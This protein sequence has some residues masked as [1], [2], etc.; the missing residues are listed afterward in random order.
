MSRY[1][2]NLGEAAEFD[3]QDEFE[4]FEILKRSLRIDATSEAESL[5]ELQERARSWMG[6]DFGVT[7]IR[8]V[9]QNMLD[10]NLIANISS[11]SEN[12]NSNVMSEWCT[13]AFNCSS[14]LGLISSRDFGAIQKV[15]AKIR[16]IANQ[17]DN[18]TI[19]IALEC[20][21]D[22]IKFEGYDFADRFE[23]LPGAHVPALGL[24][25]FIH[26]ILDSKCELSPSFGLCQA[27]FYTQFPPIL[28]QFANF[29][30]FTLGLEMKEEFFRAGLVLFADFL[31]SNAN[32]R[33]DVYTDF[34]PATRIPEHANLYFAYGSN[35]NM[36][37]MS[38]RCPSAKFV[39]LSSLK[40]FEYYIDDRGVASLRPKVGA[41]TNGIL[42]DIREPDDW[43]KLDD[44]EG[45]RYNTYRRHYVQDEDLAGDQRCAVYI[46]T[47]ATSGKPR[48]GYQE[49]IVNAVYD[50]KTHLVNEYDSMNGEYFIER[51][52]DWTRFE[53]E[54]D[55][56][57][58]DMK[59]WLGA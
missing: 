55:R 14:N 47:T 49:K 1:V 53:H 8:S 24:L 40:N 30:E 41:T 29:W 39:G 54:M 12:Y 38:S 22:P 7:S 57:A 51:G 56:W 34:A 3:A 18:T 44:C 5:R 10:E 28:Y 21:F 9:V 52:G 48:A 59:K 42:W 26:E 43:Q 23:H 4:I 20:Y 25:K 27:I 46:S 15:A 31:I 37:Q 36:Q 13:T 58:N 33:P 19:L 50:L 35:L 17:S 11:P 6:R 32:V 16:D 2:M 45:V